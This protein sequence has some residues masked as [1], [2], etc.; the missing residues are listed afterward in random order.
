MQ[1]NNILKVSVL[2]L[3][4]ALLLG[5]PTRAQAQ[6][7]ARIATIDIARIYTGYWKTK[8]SISALKE[9]GDELQ[10]ELDKLKDEFKKV[11]DD[12]KKLLADANDSAL[13]SEER[14]KRKKS[15][16]SKYK[17]MKAKDD[18]MRSF[19]T[20]NQQRRAEDEKRIF[21]GILDDI[22][23]AAAS[24]AK[25]AGYS[26]VV[27]KVAEAAQGVPVF[28]YSSDDNDITEAVLTQLNATA[29]ADAKSSK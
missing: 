29:P 18:E 12:Y 1:M 27:N 8:E 15:A 3:C 9:R 11:E 13:S 22:K 21:K 28:L 17:D 16:E 14:E 5:S 25:A 7:Q 26:M 24:K 6:S 23:S 19:V 4:G 2:L 20:V 10:K